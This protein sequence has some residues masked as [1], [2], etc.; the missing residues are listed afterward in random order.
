MRAHTRRVCGAAKRQAQLEQMIR[1]HHSKLSEMLVGDRNATREQIEGAVALMAGE[2]ASQR[3]DTARNILAHGDR[4]ASALSGIRP[5]VPEAPDAPQSIDAPSFATPVF[6][7]A[8][9]YS[10]SGF[11]GLLL[12]LAFLDHSQGLLQALHP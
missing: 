6:G 4:F 2:A 12:H 9:P 11:P 8:K 1:D 10:T 3:D 5:A 7:K